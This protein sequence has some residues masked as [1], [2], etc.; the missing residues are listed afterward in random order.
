[1][2]TS[3]DDRL[4]ISPRLTLWAEQDRLGVRWAGGWVV[5]MDNG[6]V[7]YGRCAVC[8]RPLHDPESRKRGYGPDCRSELGDEHCLAELERAKQVDRFNWLLAHHR[9]R[10]VRIA[11]RLIDPKTGRVLIDV[12]ERRIR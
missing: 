1:M 11:G 5:L 2:V 6:D 10:P 9:P 4:E 12:S 3:F 8:N 7:Q